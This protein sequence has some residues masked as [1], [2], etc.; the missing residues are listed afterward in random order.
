MDEILWAVNPKRD[1]FRDFTSFICGYAQ[2]FFNS[3]TE[4]VVRY[5]ALKAQ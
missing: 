2:E 1:A 5:M 4:A 3:R